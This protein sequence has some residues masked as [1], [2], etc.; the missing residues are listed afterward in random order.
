MTHGPAYGIGDKVPDYDLP[1]VNVNT[2]RVYYQTYKRDGCPALRE[3]LES[4]DYK[5][6]ICGHFHDAYGVYQLDN[7]V[8]T[9]VNASSC[10]EA[11]KPLNEPIVIDL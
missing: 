5:Y 1:S 11:Y 8:T 10:T 6:H 3:M 4:R 9:S 2:G 7:G